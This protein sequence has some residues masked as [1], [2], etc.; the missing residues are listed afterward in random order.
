LP[1]EIAR[2]ARCTGCITYFYT[3]GSGSGGEMGL[4][5][6][7]CQFVYDLDLTGIEVELK[8]CDNE[9]AGFE[10]LSLD[11]VRKALVSGE[12]KYNCALIIIDFLIRHGI[13]TEKEQGFIE[14]GARLH[15]RLDFPMVRYGGH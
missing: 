4:M 7:E 12:F 6:P 11:G 9:V 13:V 3:S 5:Q 2:K 8:P 1:E 10:C 14:I 15:R